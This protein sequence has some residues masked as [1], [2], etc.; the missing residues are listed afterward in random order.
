MPVGA[1]T[2]GAGGAMDIHF[3][4][5]SPSCAQAGSLSAY[6]DSTL[7]VICS[8]PCPSRCPSAPAS[9]LLR[10]LHIVHE[11]DELL[12]GGGQTNHLLSLPPPLSLSLSPALSLSLSLS[13]THTHNTHTHAHTYKHALVLE[14][15]CTAGRR[16]KGRCRTVSSLWNLT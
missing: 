3:T 5:N 14:Q 6:E 4:F 1:W 7:R 2:P 12:N 8:H 15:A 16:G 9:A 10:W 11:N 13:H